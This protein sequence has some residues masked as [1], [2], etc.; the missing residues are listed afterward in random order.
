MKE[1]SRP[2][3]TSA[4]AAFAIALL[5][6]LLAA[7]AVMAG[8]PSPSVAPDQVDDVFDI[9]NGE[10]KAGNY[11]SAV[12]LYEGLVSGS[13]L[14]T[15]EM[16]YNLGNAYFKL[17]KLGKAIAAYRR[18]LR[19]APRNEDIRANLTY[20]R[21]NAKDK[22]DRPKSTDALHEIFFFHYRVNPAE[23]EA[24]FL[25]AY[26]L[27]SLCGSAYLFWKRKLIRWATG[28]A[29]VLAVALGVNGL[30]HIHDTAHP[31][32]A[33]VIADETSVHTGPADTYMVSFNLHDGTELELHTTGAEWSQVELAD[34]RRGWIRQTDIEIVS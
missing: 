13:P 17:H 30:I 7:S 16:Y 10:Y 33:V 5:C 29:V 34:G 20:V 27:A 11:E 3:L 4:L 12:R 1:Q 9:A 2:L 8:E 19:L 24:L 21:N 26:V 32:G 6:S 14:K 28:V 22:I 15:A 25:G 23:A 18:A 31:R